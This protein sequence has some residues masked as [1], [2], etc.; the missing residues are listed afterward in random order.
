MVDVGVTSRV[1]FGIG[2]LHHYLGLVA[3]GIIAM[4]NCIHIHICVCVCIGFLALN[5]IP[6][7]VPSTV[8]G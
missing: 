5:F 6:S 4:S 2:R 1:M 8:L 3:H 7:G